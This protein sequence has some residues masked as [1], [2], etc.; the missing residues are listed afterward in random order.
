MSCHALKEGDVVGIAAPSSPFDRSLFLKGVRA[1][2]RLGFGVYHRKDIFDQNR[3][4]AGT[5]ERRASEFMELLERKDIAA[6]LFARGGY[7]SQRV[8]PLLNAQVIREHQKP[9]V[10]FSDITAL[11]TFLRQSAGVPTLYGP[12]ITQ[13]AR[14]TSG[15]SAQALAKALTTAGPLGTVPSTEAT[16][17][18]P[19]RAKGIVV[20][21]CISLINSS[22]GTPYALAV[23]NAILF[24]E[25]TG[26][27]VYVLDRM[28]TQL[29]ASGALRSARGIVFG[30]LKPLEGEAHD[31]TEMILDVL[32]DFDGPVV[33]AFPAGH[34]DSFVT[35]PLGAEAVL[36]APVVGAAPTLTYT[37]GLLS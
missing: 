5:E 24:L 20:G 26:E 30:S 33:K 10:G 32:K 11:L 21:G 28:L 1:L 16:V 35:L 23:E 7:G 25:D 4:F 13:L 22:I 37:E 14:D 3:Y 29:R 31:A 19:G 34:T 12:V 27:K 18:K 17:L 9:V 15:A 2:E 6:V 8:I 36:D